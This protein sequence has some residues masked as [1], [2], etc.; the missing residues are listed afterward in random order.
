MNDKKILK[1]NYGLL[2]VELLTSYECFEN[3]LLIFDDEFAEYF[4]FNME[5]DLEDYLYGKSYD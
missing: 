2:F 4:I 1:E 5:M 3:I